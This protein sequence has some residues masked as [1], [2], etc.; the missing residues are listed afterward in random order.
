MITPHKFIIFIS[1]SNAMHWAWFSYVA[2]I[3]DDYC[4]WLLMSKVLCEFS[5]WMITDNDSPTIGDIWEPGFKAVFHF[6]RIVAKRSV[7]NCVHIISSAWVLT[8]QWNT[9]RFATMR[10]KWKTGFIN[11]DEDPN[12]RIESFAVVIY[13]MLPQNWTDIF[14]ITIQTYKELN[15]LF[16]NWLWPFKERSGF[17]LFI[18][19]FW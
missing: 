13:V 6:N 14:M 19:P 4:R 15:I 2:D 9:L 3:G 12:L 11:I 5:P 17:L 8:K 1:G 7:F 16:R 18:L 10:L